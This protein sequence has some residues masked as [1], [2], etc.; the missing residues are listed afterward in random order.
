MMYSNLLSYGRG[1]WPIM[2]KLQIVGMVLFKLLWNRSHRPYSPSM[3]LCGIETGH[4][5]RRRSRPVN[6]DCSISRQQASRAIHLVLSPDVNALLQEDSSD[7]QRLA[8]CSQVQG[9][10]A[11]LLIRRYD[12]SGHR[13]TWTDRIFNDSFANF[14]PTDLIL[15]C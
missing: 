2:L 7:C 3:S 15:T 11:S 12:K 10:V 13:H 8:E 4:K 9:C 14:M 5:S 1:H 6:T